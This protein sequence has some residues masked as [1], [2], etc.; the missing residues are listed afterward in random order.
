MKIRFAEDFPTMKFSLLL[1][2]V[3][4]LTAL[5]FGLVSGF[6]L[7]PIIGLSIGVAILILS[8]SSI[9]ILQYLLR[10]K[11]YRWTATVA[12]FVKKRLDFLRFLLQVLF[13]NPYA[14]LKAENSDCK[15][16]KF[17]AERE[18]NVSSGKTFFRSG[19]FLLNTEKCR[20]SKAKKP[21][22]R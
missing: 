19:L 6:A 1:G 13:M 22:R 8:F 16:L 10:N 3:I 15:H 12:H 18:G 21:A 14:R 4:V 7:H 2:S 20:R 17:V 5:V 9:F 11:N